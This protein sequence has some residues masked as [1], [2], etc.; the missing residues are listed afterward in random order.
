MKLQKLKQTSDDIAESYYDSPDADAFYSEIW[1]GE[2]IHVGLYDEQ[3][4]GDIAKASRATVH[5]MAEVMHQ[6]P[7]HACVLDLGAGYG[8]SARCLAREHGADVICI[9]ISEVENKRNRKLNQEQNLDDQIIVKHGSFG[10]VPEPDDTVDVVWSQDAFLHA[11]DRSQVIKEAARVLKA[12]GEM[13]FTDPMQ[14]D[15]IED[16]SALQPI[17]DRI[18]LSSLASPGFYESALAQAGFTDIHFEDLSQ[19]LRHHYARVR[20][21]LLANRDTLSAKISPDYVERMEKGLCHWI[22]G[23]DRGLIVWGVISARLQ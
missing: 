15:V 2:D 4:R 6:A 17:Y 18:H 22:S 12:G 5:H 9:N 7:E 11:H 13:V 1:G 14:A 21:E 16:P 23:A 19:H 20:E 10:H 3:G 8:G